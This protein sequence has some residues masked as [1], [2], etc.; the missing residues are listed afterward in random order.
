[1]ASKHPNEPAMHCTAKDFLLVNEIATR[2]I[3][4]GVYANAT[5][6]V[7]PPIPLNSPPP[8][9]TVVGFKNAND[10]LGLLIGQAK[11]NSQ[12]VQDRNAQSKAVYDMLNLK[13]RP[14]VKQIANGDLT[15]INKS[16]FDNNAQPQKSAVPDSPVIKK[17]TEGKE[18][19]TAKIFL[20]RKKKKALAAEKATQKSTKG[21]TYSAQTTTTPDNEESWKTVL[22]AVS[23]TKLII[24]N[25]TAKI[26]V[27]VYAINAAGK[28]KPSNPFPFTQ[29]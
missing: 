29:Q 23:S 5:I 25:V 2:V 28:S 11:G 10:L 1:M 18:A 8:P 12:K 26:F 20:D 27:R 22:E 14:Y 13:L 7:T 21:N 6:F 9:S 4:Q 17:I 15:V 24:P 16:G 19:H 3:T